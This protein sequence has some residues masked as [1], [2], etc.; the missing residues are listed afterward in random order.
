VQPSGIFSGDV[1]N[2]ENIQGIRGIGNN[3]LTPTQ[4]YLS[5]INPY[6][7]DPYAGTSFGLSP[8]LSS[9]NLSTTNS[10]FY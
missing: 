5:S 6:T 7:P 10:T 1:A 9:T 4:D 3:L 2:I 8:N